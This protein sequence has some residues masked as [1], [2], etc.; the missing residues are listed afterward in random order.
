MSRKLLTLAAVA[1]LS[2]IH[3]AAAPILEQRSA[4]SFAQMPVEEITVFKDGHNFV[5]HEAILPVNPMGQVVLDY[6]P[7]PVIGTFWPY[8]ADPDR[9]LV[10]VKSGKHM[11]A[12]ER[13]ALDLYHLLAANPG[14][15]LLV[16]ESGAEPYSAVIEGIPERSSS[17]LAGTAPSGADEALPEKGSIILLRTYEG[18]RV[19]PVQSIKKVTF[20]DPPRSGLTEHE[21]RDLLTLKL[22]GEAKK[23][24]TARVGMVYLQK[25]IRWIPSYKI[26]MDG[27]GNAKIQLQATLLNEMIDLDDVTANLVVGVPSFAFKDT[28]DPI[29]LQEAAAQL[30]QHFQEQSRT[31]YAFS[32]AIMSQS[33]RMSEYR[34]QGDGGSAPAEEELT[35]MGKDEDLYVFTIEHITLGKGERLVVPLVEFDLGYEDVY[36][37]DLPIRPPSD[38]RRNFSSQQHRELAELLNAPKVMHEIRMVNDSEWPITTAPALLFHGKQLLGQGMTTYTAVGG[39]LDVTITAAVDIQVRVSAHETSRLP[40]DLEWRSHRYCRIDMEGNLFLCNRLD[41]KVKIEIVRRMAGCIDSAGNDGKIVQNDL[42]DFAE[43]F[44]GAGAPYWW[45]WYSWPWWWYHLN[46]YGKVEWN[47]ALE[48][49]ESGE[50]KCAWHYYWS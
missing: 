20:K 18:V 37:L 4:E 13:T 2:L 32:N 26:V 23:G 29:A 21:F 10:S 14:A 44:P 19:V 1:A 24:G 38:V 9:P 16:E 31:A 12:I 34:G 17:E 25:G 46:G 7:R 8:S 5:L 43:C 3:A 27:K 42:Y 39:S 40:N 48:P 11:V 22:G 33:A 30:S 35:G 41:K 6:L 50:L 49:G 47:I 36:T 15:E 45:H 28:I